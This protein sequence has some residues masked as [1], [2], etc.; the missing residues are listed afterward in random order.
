MLFVPMAL[1]CSNFM[2]ESGLSVR[3]M[4]LAVGSFDMVLE[5]NALRFVAGLPH[6]PSLRFQT[7]GMNLAGLSCDQQTLL[8][9]SYPSE[10]IVTTD[11]FCGFILSNFR[12]VRQ[13]V[14]AQVTIR[15]GL[16]TNTHFVIRDGRESLVIEGNQTYLDL[17]DGITGFGIL[18]NEP[19]FPFHVE[20]VLNFN[21]KNSR[22][23]PGTWYPDDRFLRIHLVKRNMKAATYEEAVQQA[24]HVLNTVTVPPNMNMGVDSYHDHTLY[25]VIYDHFNKFVYYRTQYNHQLQRINLT[26]ALARGESRVLSVDYEL[27]WFNDITDLFDWA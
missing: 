15:A 9:A 26:A 17:N 11:S 6:V 1:A 3:T 19:P 25:G 20:N 24:L 22:T 18:T 7:G 8:N 21:W 4:D 13:V 5:D 14:E 23:I 2:M 27:P 10:G 12:T 16:V